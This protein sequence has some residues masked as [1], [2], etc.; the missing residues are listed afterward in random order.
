MI[1]LVSVVIPTRDRLDLLAQTVHTVLAQEV[2]L[3]VIVVDE[4]STD[5]TT[6]WLTSHSGPR[7][8]TIRHDRPRG[9]SSARNAG[10]DA[11][12]GGWVA[13]VDDDDL[14]LPGKLGD[15]LTAAERAGSR[16]AFGGALDITGEPRLLRVTMPSTEDAA[17]LLWSN[18]IPGGGSNVLVRRDLLEAAGGFDPRV[19]IVADWDLWIRLSRLSLPAVVP[20]PVLAYR[21]HPGNM[22]RKV[23]EMIA[24]MRVIESR[25]RTE[26]GDEGI[27]WDDAFRWIGA[28]ALRAGDRAAARRVALAALRA[29]HAG[30]LR[31][32]VRAAAPVAPRLP[33]AAD[34]DRDASAFDR[35]R[36]RPVV[37]WPPGT[38]AWLRRTLQVTAA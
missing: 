4:A 38:E 7:L 2:D 13:F 3:E 6:A 31:R 23:D 29:G 30:S 16:W 37:Q 11:S 35:I 17:H 24:G 15:Q 33:I 14:W 22:S 9:L 27:D 8:R 25:Y 12:R 1:P 36:P 5:G 21:I 19:P 34:D 18:V 20:R 10:V 26:R 28:S 32:L